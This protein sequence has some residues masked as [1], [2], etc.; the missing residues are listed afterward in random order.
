MDEGRRTGFEVR[1]V[2]LGTALWCELIRFAE[3]WEWGVGSVLARRMR[4]GFGDGYAVFAA[5][6]GG[7]LSGACTLDKGAG[8][9]LS[10][11]GELE[12]A[13]GSAASLLPFI[14]SV[15][16]APQARG[17]RLSGCLCDTACA[18]AKELR[19]RAAYLVSGDTGLYEKYGFEPVAMT[20]TPWGRREPVFRKRLSGTVDEA[21]A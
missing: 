17:H 13:E 10:S 18:L 2:L 19:F 7:E 5:F 6:L 14:G 15:Y 8:W 11:A 20:D 16:I 3:G 9:A 1:Q 4:G 12:N 21:I